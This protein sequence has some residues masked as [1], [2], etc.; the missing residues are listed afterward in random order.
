MAW[1]EDRSINLPVTFLIRGKISGTR[2][3]GSST[4]TLW[5]MR[6][7]KPLILAKCGESPIFPDIYVVFRQICLIFGGI[8]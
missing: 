7:Q 2:S 1:V 3:G 5:R 8:N 4:K 6:F